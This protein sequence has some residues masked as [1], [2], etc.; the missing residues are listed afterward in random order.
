MTPYTIPAAVADMRHR[1]SCHPMAPLLLHRLG[2]I[3][4]PAGLTFVVGALTAGAWLDGDLVAC[5][6]LEAR[7]DR[8]AERYKVD[9]QAVAPDG[10][11]LYRR[12]TK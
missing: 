2:S 12:M 11:V 9:V 3:A 6:K 10:T 8:V 5:A 7:I 1:L 4:R